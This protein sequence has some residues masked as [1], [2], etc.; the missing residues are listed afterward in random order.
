MSEPHAGPVGRSSPRHG[1]SAALG[2][3]QEPALGE[4]RKHGGIHAFSPG[5]P[6]PSG[7]RGRGGVLSAFGTDAAYL[8]VHLLSMTSPE[9]KVFLIFPY[10]SNFPRWRAL[11]RINGSIR[12]DQG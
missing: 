5:V 3:E 7:V 12:F 8:Q 9:V 11:V 1:S 6:S 2:Q 10:F 4:G